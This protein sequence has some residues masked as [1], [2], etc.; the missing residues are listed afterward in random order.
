MQELTRIQK[1]EHVKELINGSSYARYLFHIEE[2]K[3]VNNGIVVYWAM[4]I[5]HLKLFINEKDVYIYLLKGTLYYDAYEYSHFIE[6]YVR[7]WLF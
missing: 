7:G 1:C 6:D 5:E 3:P 2:V 4:G